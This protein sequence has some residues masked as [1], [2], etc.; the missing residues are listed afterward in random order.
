[1]IILGFVLMIINV[2]ICVYIFHFKQDVLGGFKKD[3]ILAVVLEVILVLICIFFWWISTKSFYSPLIGAL[4]LGSSALVTYL[5]YFSVHLSESVKIRTKEVSE[6]LVGI[7]DAGDSNLDGHS[8]HVCYLTM[9]LYDYLPIH[10]K[11]QINEENLW[12]A[13]MFHDLGK[14]GIPGKILNKPGKLSGD[15]WLSMKRHPEIGVEILK[16]IQ[17]FDVV[18]DWILYHHE[19]MDGNGYHHLKG[20]EIPLA[21]RIIAVA[22]TYSAVFMARSYK[23]RRTHEEAITIVKMA[24]G[25]QLDAELVDIFCKIPSERIEACSRE[26]RD[27]MK[28]YLREDFREN[29]VLNI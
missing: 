1:M 6:A 4:L 29:K 17:S 23:A 26:V 24:A 27:R 19:R 5:L 12:F 15:E 25:S 9:L 20:E 21:A 22:D 7:L 11:A 2:C 18:S 28:S 14:L 13:A 3:R 10:Y 16:P 8:L